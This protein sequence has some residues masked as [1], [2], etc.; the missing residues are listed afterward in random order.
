MQ[1]QFPHIKKLLTLT[2][3]TLFLLYC[4][5]GIQQTDA[6]TT[7][8]FIFNGPYYD[9][10]TIPVGIGAW[11][12]MFNANGTLYQTI[13]VSTA[14][15]AN[16]TT[17]I[18][19][20]PVTS[21]IWLDP[22]MQLLNVTRN[23]TPE[24]SGSETIY[25]HIPSANNP[26]QTYTFNI[27]DFYGMT[28]PYLLSSV[29]HDGS[30]YVVE[31]QSLN[32]TGIVSF[33][34]SQWQPYTLTF[35]CDQGTHSQSFYSSV[36]FT[37]NLQILAGTFPSS[38]TNDS[39]ATAVRTNDTTIDITYYDPDGE[40]DWLYIAIT[41]QD[42]V[43]FVTDYTDNQTLTNSYSTTA[44][45]DN[46]TDYYVQVQAYRYGGIMEWDFA[47]PV[48]TLTNPFTGLLD[49]LGTW[50]TGFDPAQLFA[51]AIIMCALG[52]G[53]FRSAGVSCV[54]AWILAGIFTAIGWFSIGIPMLAFSGVISI[55]VVLA[56]GKETTRDA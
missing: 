18:S 49:Y 29:T 17:V 15:D 16:T 37:N 34:M 4:F 3:L 22:T 13:L 50:P 42:G 43:Y 20:T 28:N 33:I 24:N 32:T 38:A 47:C 54:L 23:Y 7:Y 25:I 27:A 35:Q 9:D 26:I 55:L 41:H 39:L 21:I 11:I 10:G 2:I 52:L 8:T 12:A 6:Q 40:T 5:S 36:T 19:T 45:V 48:L 56:E 30:S 53:S 1:S 31:R 44:T 14:G 51:A 46:A